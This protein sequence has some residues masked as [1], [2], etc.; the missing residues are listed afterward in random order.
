MCIN[1][2][3]TKY[4]NKSA[5]EFVITFAKEKMDKNEEYIQLFDFNTG[6]LYGN[7][8]KGSEYEAK[9]S[10]SNI[11]INC[12][13][14]IHNHIIPFHPNPSDDDIHEILT[15]KI[16]FSIITS[17]NEIWIMKYMNIYPI[18]KKIITEDVNNIIK[19]C[20]TVVLDDLINKKEISQE[21]KNNIYNDIS[22]GFLDEKLY[23][24]YNFLKPLWVCIPNAIEI[25]LKSKYNIEVFRRSI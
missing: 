22:L 15:K 6:E 16:K 11:P 21:D 20:L 8:I 7:E 24:K 9:A 13:A 12:L 4:F 3:L 17:K 19:D 14:L 18:D 2:P 23:N 25:Y 10:F 1:E 5:V